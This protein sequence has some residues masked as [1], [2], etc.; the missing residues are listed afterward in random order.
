MSFVVLEV[1]MRLLLDQPLNLKVAQSSV[2][3]HRLSW[4]QRTQRLAGAVM[5]RSPSLFLGATFL[6]TCATLPSFAQST[7]PPAP[8]QP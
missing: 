2:G 1:C 7:Q 3:D 6:I 4:V 8:D 5:R